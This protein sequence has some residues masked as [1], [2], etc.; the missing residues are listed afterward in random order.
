MKD[1]DGRNMGEEKE[2]KDNREREQRGRVEVQQRSKCLLNPYLCF[3]ST[4]FTI[5]DME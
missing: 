1:K 3:N 4:V 2:N 5:T